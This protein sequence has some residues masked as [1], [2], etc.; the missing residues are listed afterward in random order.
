MLYIHVYSKEHETHCFT[1]LVWKMKDNCRLITTEIGFIIV[2]SSI[3][4]K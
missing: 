3:L 4:L 2:Q 1:H